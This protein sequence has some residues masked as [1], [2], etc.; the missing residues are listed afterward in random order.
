[1]EVVAETTNVDPAAQSV[2]FEIYET[3]ILT[4][5]E[6]NPLHIKLELDGSAS[7]PAETVVHGFEPDFEVNVEIF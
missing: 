2:T 3:N 5:L 6:T 1:M 4:Y 7:L